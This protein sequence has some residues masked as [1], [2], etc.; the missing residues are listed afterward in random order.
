MPDLE[1]WIKKQLD[2]GYSQEQV[3]QSLLKAGYSKDDAN[4]A[5]QKVL[6]SRKIKNKTM[7]KLPTNLIIAAIILVVVLAVTTYYF[8]P[9]KPTSETNSQKPFTEEQCRSLLIQEDPSVANMKFEDMDLYTDISGNFSLRNVFH[10]KINI[11]GT[12]DKFYKTLYYD[13]EPADGK[14]VFFVTSNRRFQGCCIVNFNPY[15]KYIEGARKYQ[16]PNSTIFLKKREKE[17]Y[18]FLENI[19]M[20]YNLFNLK[21]ICFL[22]KKIGENTFVPR[23]EYCKEVTA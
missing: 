3:F 13:K 1:E 9:Q 14:H 22:N 12:E 4:S 6:N 11:S 19:D 16:C 20:Y 18:I 21:R 10:W 7:S 23:K 8:Y 2:S 15:E 17:N 5:I